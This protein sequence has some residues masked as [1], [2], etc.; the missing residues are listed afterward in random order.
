MRLTLVCTTPTTVP[1]IIVTAAMTDSTGIQYACSGSSDDR[2]TRAKAANAAALTLVDMNAVTIVGAPSYASGVHIWK[3]TAET[4]KANP[5][6]SSATANSAMVLGVPVPCA[7]ESAV[8]ISSI[9]V[10]P[11]KAYA[12]AT[13]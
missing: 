6:A 11:D 2:N 1:T 8:P 7:R 4:L 12:N 10:E 13:P 5:T 9:R 3:G